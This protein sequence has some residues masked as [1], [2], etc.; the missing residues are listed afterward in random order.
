MTKY[1]KNAEPHKVF[2]IKDLIDY[3]DGGV[4][5]ISLV[6]R[7]SLFMKI[8]AVAKGAEIPTHS[9]IGDVLVTVIEG[10]AEI[11]LED[12]VYNLKTSESLLMPANAPHS[13]KASNSSF[14]IFVSQVKEEK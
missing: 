11:T 4:N 7:D 8:L 3:K 6:D 13:L 5:A 14:K 2:S 9:G 1:I 10:E 12:K